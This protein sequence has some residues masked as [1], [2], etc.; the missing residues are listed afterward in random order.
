MQTLETDAV[1]ARWSLVGCR[2]VYFGHQSVGSGVVAGME[3][4][5]AARSVPIRFVQ[6]RDPSAVPS[7]A[8]VHFLVGQHRDYASKN[9]DLLRLL[10]AD[11][12][13]DSPIVILKYCYADSN[14]PVDADRM[15]DAYRE[16]LESI[17]YEHPDA[18]VVHSTIPLTTV[19]GAFKTAVKHVF[20]MSTARDQALAR[21]RYNELLRWE[22]EGKEPIFDLA[23]IESRDAD[24]TTAGFVAGG[25]LVET[26]APANTTDGAH[27]N[28]RGRRLAAKTLLDVLSGVIAAEQ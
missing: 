13:A 22:F 2:T 7:P 25:T 24:G 14:P 16:T 8:F 15:F 11:E 28:E 10:D 5:A 19:E 17:R 26:M 20:N 23:R 9:A 18:S 4:L 6:S 27:L 21:H 12:R 1:T 3:S